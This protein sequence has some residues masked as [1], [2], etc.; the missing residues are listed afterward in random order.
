[1]YGSL[2]AFLRYQV[3]SS[4]LICVAV[5]CFSIRIV[6]VILFISPCVT[7]GTLLGATFGVIPGFLFIIFT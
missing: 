7:I 6:G 5:L 1:M 3:E 2:T 4:S